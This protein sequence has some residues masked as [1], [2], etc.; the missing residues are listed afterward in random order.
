VSRS[1]KSVRSPKA[2][3]EP[4][5]RLPTNLLVDPNWA[6]LRP[7][8]RVLF[9]DMC[10]QYRHGGAYG[11]TN[12]S[13]IGYGCV[14]GARAINASPATASRR[15]QELAKNDFIRLRKVGALKVKGEPG[16]ASEWELSIY[17]APGKAPPS[18]GDRWLRLEHWMLEAPAYREL[19]NRAKCILLEL[20]RRFDGGN[21]GEIIFGGADGSRAGFSIDVTERAL[22]ELERA[23]FI[24]M[25]A[26][27]VPYQERARQWRLTMYRAC[28]KPATKE[29][30]Q[31]PTQGQRTTGDRFTGT[32]PRR[33]FQRCGYCLCRTQPRALPIFETH[34]MKTIH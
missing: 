28:G 24:V 21:N 17:P 14:A 30:M 22:T 18:W 11:F 9:V 1:P 7:A 2:R 25:V 6:G 26:K 33:T 4:F 10:K 32:A 16:L 19:T 3:R 5:S 12:N 20:M 13:K 27:A 31:A 15:L 34:S 29:F 23:G 8:A